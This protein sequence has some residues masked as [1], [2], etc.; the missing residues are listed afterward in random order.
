MSALEQAFPLEGGWLCLGFC[1]TVGWHSGAYRRSE[2]YAGEQDWER[3]EDVPGAHERFAD[4]RSLIGWSL[5]KRL[6][7]VSEAKT[8]LR[9]MRAM[10]AQ[11]EEVRRRAIG[12]REALYHLF[13]ALAAEKAPDARDVAALNAWLPDAMARRRL[14]HGEA[15]FTWE[16]AA[17][18]DELER[19]LWP[20]VWS[21]A[22][23]LTAGPLERVRE[24]DN[25]PCGWLFVDSSRNRTRR[26]CD[27]R[28]CGNRVKARRHYARTRET[29]AQPAG[30]SAS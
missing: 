25:D 24:C 13:S 19:V 7:T 16:S 22:E 26:W 11:A 18:A 9:A 6:V 21:A 1:N 30:S 28:D 5:R 8:L 10:P 15:G 2:L 14:T 3:A 23:L 12:L 20:V 17:P 29:K 27:M 4:Y